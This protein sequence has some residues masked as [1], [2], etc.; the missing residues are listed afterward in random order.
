MEYGHNSFCRICKGRELTKFLSLGNM[1][2]VD[3]FVSK[4]MILTEKKYP[5]DVYFCH[6]CKLVQLLDVVP[7]EVLFNKS[8]A[9]F[10]SAS[11]PLVRHFEMYASEIKKRV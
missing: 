7:K 4:E 6:N 10:S 11:L 2:P 9:Y 8:Y 3:S 5:L 1:P